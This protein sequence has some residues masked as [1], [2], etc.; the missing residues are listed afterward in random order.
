MAVLGSGCYLN[1]GLGSVGGNGATAHLTI[2]IAVPLGER[3]NVRLGG[4]VATGGDELVPGPAALGFDVN[5]LGKH[6]ALTTVADVALP[7]GGNWTSSRS[8]LPEDVGRVYAGIGYTY[9]T[10]Q[11][12]KVKDVDRPAGSVTVSA[13]PE[14]FWSGS[15]SKLG[16]AVD[17]LVVGRGWL[18]ARSLDSK[19]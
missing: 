4:N 14:M 10:W 16:G 6:H 8:D 19:D 15:D 11:R 1:A 3:G 7:V 9:T 5:L 12:D 13:G 17:I 18:F 2:G